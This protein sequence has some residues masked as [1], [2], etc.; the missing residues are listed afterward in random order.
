MKPIL[1]VGSAN[2]DMV[3]TT[4]RLPQPGQTLLGGRFATFLGGKG[5]NQAVAAARAGGTVGFLGCVGRDDAGARLRAGLA[6]E[7]IDTRHL[8]NVN[9]PSGTALITTV[10]GGDNMIVVAPGAN[11]SLEPDH[12]P[13]AAFDA[14]GTVLAQLEIAMP[15]VQAAATMARAC[16][17]TFILDPAPAVPLPPGLIRQVDWLTPNESEARLLL[18]DTMGDLD[19]ARAS[20]AL[21]ARGARG[22]VLTMGARGVVLLEAGRDPVTIAAQRVAAVDTTAAGD[23]FNGA[24]AVAL[25]EGAEPGAAVQ[26]AIAAA[27]I[28]VTREGAQ[29]A[30]PHRREIDAMLSADAEERR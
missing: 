29:A 25:A 9:E 12:L 27:S 10:P 18:D 14:V 23:A 4:D 3:V 22:V 17:A 30:M 7:G 5:A 26:F 16:G 11:L 28:A 15:S 6:A 20:L 19:G 21:Q 2:V 1:V 24:F 8:L 13:A